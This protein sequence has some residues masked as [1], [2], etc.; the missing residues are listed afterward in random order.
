MATA[1]LVEEVLGGDLPPGS[2]GLRRQSQPVGRCAGHVGGALAG[3]VVLVILRQ[4]S[5]ASPGPTW[6]GTWTCGARSGRCWTS[7]TAC[8]TSGSSPRRCCSWSR[9][10]G[11]GA[12]STGCHRR[13]G[14]PPPR[15]APQPGRGRGRGRHHYDVSNA[16]YRMVLGPTMTYSCAVFH[17]AADTLEQAQENKYGK[18]ICRKLGV[19]AG[20]AAARRGG[21]AGAA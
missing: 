20:H 4:A 16:F 12:T 5:W 18:L 17:D 14:G 2:R 11:A 3:R 7:G 1:P 19:G 9:S 13:G 21:A 8:R 6:P 10:W 15:Q